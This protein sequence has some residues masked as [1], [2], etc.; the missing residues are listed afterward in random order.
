M[1]WNS[2]FSNKNILGLIYNWKLLWRN[3]IM[4]L[5][6]S[7]SGT[8]WCRVKQKKKKEKKQRLSCQI[9]A[10]ATESDSSSPNTGRIDF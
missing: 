10:E 2:L 6:L 8:L 1:S 9:N 7:S 5:I 4:F 3:E